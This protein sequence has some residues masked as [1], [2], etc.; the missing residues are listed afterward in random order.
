MIA[1]RIMADKV[2][3][4]SRENVNPTTDSTA[5]PS[6]PLVFLLTGF[7]DGRDEANHGGATDKCF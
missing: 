3:P 4:G 1:T 6:E 7:Q 2:A 5:K